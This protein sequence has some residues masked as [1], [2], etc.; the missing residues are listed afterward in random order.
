MNVLHAY[1]F[2]G[3]NENRLERTCLRQILHASTHIGTWKDI[4]FPQAAMAVVNPWN[5]F[6][7]TVTLH[8]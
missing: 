2:W 7:E 4:C 8:T 6:P 1:F 3:G 5:I